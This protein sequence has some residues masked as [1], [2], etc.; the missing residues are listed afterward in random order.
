MATIIQTDSA[1]RSPLASTPKIVAMGDV[2]ISDSF[3]RAGDLQ[4]SSTDSAL[5]GVPTV[6]GGTNG[7]NNKTVTD[8]GGQLVLASTSLFSQCV[9]AGRPDVSVSF[10]LVADTAGRAAGQQSM[11]EFRKAAADT[12]DTLRLTLGNYSNASGVAQTF[13]QLY[14]R[15]GGAATALLSQFVIVHGNTIRVDIKGSTLTIYTND[16]LLMTYPITDNSLLTGTFFGFAG[17][18]GNKSF[19][20]K[21]YMIRSIN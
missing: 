18:S 11:I 21:D 13:A 14:K 20:I 15:V 1:I 4:G 2:F 3:N 19:T 9:N 17:A 16:V 10:K 8:N 12:G 7:N 6:W 5:G